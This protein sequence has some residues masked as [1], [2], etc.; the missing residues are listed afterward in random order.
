LQ[1]KNHSLTLLRL[2]SLVMTSNISIASAIAFATDRLAHLD[3]KHLEAEIL[4]CWMLRVERSYLRIWPE[5]QLLPVQWNCLEQLLQRRARGEPFAYIRGWQ[6]FWSLNLR[7]T[8]ATLIP[9][10]ETEQLVE[11]SLKRMDPEQ[12]LKVADLGTGSGAIALAIASER[13]QAQVVATDISAAALEIA[14]ENKSRLGLDKVTF[15]LGD[16]FAPLIDERFDLIV[17]NPPYIAEGDLHLI[18]DGLC[19]EPN[20]ALIAGD[21]GLA[22]IRHIATVAREYLVDGGW[23]LLEHGYDQ[24]QP[25]LALLTKLGYQQVADFCDLAGLP[26]VAVGQWRACWD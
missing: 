4:L 13:P 18:Q 20:S 5:R 12:I 24:G 22:S 7:V 19:F 15:R 23:L 17:S 21:N 1:T 9:R 11:L 10:P 14:R 8:E 3:S 25:L 6:E 26:R 2:K 16:W